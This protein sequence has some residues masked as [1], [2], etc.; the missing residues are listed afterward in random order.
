MDYRQKVRGG[1]SIISLVHPASAPL[2]PPSLTCD[3]GER[4]G[5]IIRCGAMLGP[6]RRAGPTCTTNQWHTQ[7]WNKSPRRFPP[8]THSHTQSIRLD[9]LH[10]SRL[11]SCQGEQS[12]DWTGGEGGRTQEDHANE[13]PHRRRRCASSSTKATTLLS[14]HP[15]LNLWEGHWLVT[16]AIWFS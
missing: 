7:R 5:W 9:S 13:G 11:M 1:T 3:R 4:G 6:I 8:S 12:V 10:A 2:P 16:S 15:L 14:P